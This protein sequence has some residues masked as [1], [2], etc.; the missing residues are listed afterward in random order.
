MGSGSSV[1][2]PASARLPEARGWPSLNSLRL[3]TPF[4]LTFKLA[5][6]MLMK[7]LQLC[8]ISNAPTCQHSKRMDRVGTSLHIVQGGLGSIY[9]GFFDVRQAIHSLCDRDGLGPV[10][11]T[12]NVSEAELAQRLAWLPMS[13]PAYGDIVVPRIA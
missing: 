13:F 1:S 8:G 4:K 2:R 11:T 5:P 9:R 12:R 6:T 10:T 3:Q 7:P